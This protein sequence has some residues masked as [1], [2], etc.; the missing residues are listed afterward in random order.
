MKKLLLGLAL[1]PGCAVFDT[2][3]KLADSISAMAETVALKAMSELK[4]GGGM[5]H[6]Q[7]S[8][9]NPEYQIEFVGG[10]VI[11][12]H[13]RIRFIGGSLSGNIS[14]TLVEGDVTDEMRE[15]AYA[16]LT[17]PATTRAEQEKRL[18]EET[19]RNRD[20]WLR[21]FG[22]DPMKPEEPGVVATQPVPVVE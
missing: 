20:F 8:L 4:A 12:G 22:G 9:T 7:G 10:P 21:L 3:P 11:Y 15:R 13:V 5:A 14:T 17:S 16:I 2:G 6:V 19:Q 18:M 1:L